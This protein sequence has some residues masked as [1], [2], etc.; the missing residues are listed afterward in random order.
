M[1]P[2]IFQ[3]SHEKIVLNYNTGTGHHLAGKMNYAKKELLI[4]VT[5]R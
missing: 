3:V 4:G 2:D 5:G 1:L